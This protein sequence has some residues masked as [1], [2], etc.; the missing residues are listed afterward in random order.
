MLVVTTDDLVGKLAPVWAEVFSRLGWQHRVRVLA[1]R[2]DPCELADLAEE[3]ARFAPR[4]L[5]IAAP[6]EVAAALA[7]IACLEA[8]KVV[9]WP[10]AARLP[11]RC[12]A[13]AD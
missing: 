6:A 8:V 12:D 3:A 7:G 1:T 4:L 11:E 2:V 9:D 10:D 5:L 13:P